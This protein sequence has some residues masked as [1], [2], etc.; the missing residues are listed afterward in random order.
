MHVMLKKQWIYSYGC[1]NWNHV[2][3]AYQL[4]CFRASHCDN[5]SIP[6]WALQILQTYFRS[7]HVMSKAYQNGDSCNSFHV[8]VIS[9]QFLSCSICSKRKHE[10]LIMPHVHY[11]GLLSHVHELT[12]L[13]FLLSVLVL[14]FFAMASSSSSPATVT[15]AGFAKPVAPEPIPPAHPPPSRQAN[16]QT[17]AK[18][19]PSKKAR[20]GSQITIEDAASLPIDPL[21]LGHHSIILAY[22]DGTY[23]S[24]SDL[25]NQQDHE[26]RP[27]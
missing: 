16:V 19:P 27:P 13:F 21:N 3:Q 26:L 17:E 11:I 1:S 2:Y 5:E 8:H 20:T 4:K 18:A 7:C 12:S 22:G 6:Q 24:P 15:K 9:W 10:S 14:S 25:A 23:G